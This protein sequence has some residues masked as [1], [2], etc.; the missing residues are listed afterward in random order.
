MCLIWYF[1]SNGKERSGKGR[2]K[3]GEDMMRLLFMGDER[4]RREERK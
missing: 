2:M 1:N 3:R 4:G